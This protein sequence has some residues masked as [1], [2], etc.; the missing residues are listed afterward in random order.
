LSRLWQGRECAEWLLRVVRLVA[1]DNQETRVSRG[2]VRGM[3]VTLSTLED[4]DDV[5]KTIKELYEIYGSEWHEDRAVWVLK[6]ISILERNQKWRR[7]FEASFRALLTNKDLM[8]V[9]DD[10]DEYDN[11]HRMVIVDLT[12][13]KTV[14]ID[15]KEILGGKT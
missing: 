12:G 11:P 8:S 4:L 5:I 6:S 13:Q 14:F 10:M 7:D 2:G 1:Q 3:T 15:V 9:K